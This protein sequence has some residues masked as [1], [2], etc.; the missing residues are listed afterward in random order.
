M[1]FMC[2]NLLACSR[3]PTNRGYLTLLTVVSVEKASECK[4]IILN[5]SYSFDTSSLS[6]AQDDKHQIERRCLCNGESGPGAGTGTTFFLLGY[7]KEG[8]YKCGAGGLFDTCCKHRG[9]WRAG[10]WKMNSPKMNCSTHSA[11]RVC[12]SQEI[13]IKR[14]FYFARTLFSRTSCRYYNLPEFKW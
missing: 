3:R 12:I 10:N 1:W 9:K 4:E 2:Q 6:L 11:N 13:W 5:S 8:W 7:H 14:N